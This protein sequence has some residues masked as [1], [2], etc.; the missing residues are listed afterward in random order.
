[1]LSVGQG[2]AH[3][4]VLAGRT[5]SVL[6]GPRGYDRARFDLG[7]SIAMCLV[8][9]GPLLV[10]GTPDEESYAQAVFS[11][12]MFWRYLFA[13]ADPNWIGDYGVGTLGPS[14]NWLILNFATAVSAW[15]GPQ[16]IYRAVWMTGAVGASF[17]CMR[18]LRDWDVG[19]FIRIAAG[20]TVLLS[21]PALAYSYVNDW[22]DTF[23]CWTASFVV[24]WA[25]LRLSRARIRSEIVQS[26]L[27]AG[28][29]AGF[30]AATS[31]PS[32]MFAPAYVLVIVAAVLIAHHP[33]LILFY[34][35][36]A[37][38]A[39][40]IASPLLLVVAR[41]I[42]EPF[43]A[44]EHRE[45]SNV[46]LSYVAYLGLRP[47][48]NAV[49]GE[50]VARLWDPYR[51]IFFGGVFFSGAVIFSCVTL[52]R[53]QHAGSGDPRIGAN[54]ALAIGFIAAVT[55][56]FAPHSFGLNLINGMWL[57]RD[58]ATLLGIPLAAIALSRVR[59][60]AVRNGLL[61]LHVLQ[62]GVV[63]I[64]PLSGPM[65]PKVLTNF[66][67]DRDGSFAT[68]LRDAD[69]PPH[70][71]ISL[72]GDLARESRRDMGGSG[73]SSSSD[74][75]RLGYAVVND[76]TWRGFVVPN[77]AATGPSKMIQG[78]TWSETALNS[79]TVRDF[80]GVRYVVGFSDEAQNRFDTT[81]LTPKV[82]ASLT[83]Q[84]RMATVFE[85]PTAWPRATVLSQEIFADYARLGPEVRCGL[86]CDPIDWNAYKIANPLSIELRD[87]SMLIHL[88]GTQPAGSILVI[89]QAFHAE[90]RV[91][92]D[93]RQVEPDRFLGAFGYV[94]L[95]GNERQILVQFGSPTKNA[96]TLVSVMTFVGGVVGLAVLGRRSRRRARGDGDRL[97]VT[98]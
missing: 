76:V 15:L 68:M 42:V 45:V 21:S 30:M 43:G 41:L 94:P 54:R 46:P 47:F 26:T 3:G 77:L 32:A 87:D 6:N 31:P 36:A 7:M 57:F 39:A 96:L 67:F 65:N 14:G 29:A 11:T 12:E 82:S 53:R 48:S 93:G 27:T 64:A 81:G 25:I 55:L 85:N 52:F 40:V 16:A 74:L 71:R 10:Y 92:V 63:S 24:L 35:V 80:L 97:N 70:A 4:T 18:I 50:H 38:I 13:G 86:A 98:L 61:G 89:T 8:V 66:R 91:V 69:I 78:L 34:A 88:D 33:R 60:G 49:F 20:F 90:W 84:G 2:P 23:S 79:S 72:A 37:A 28:L 17:F 44:W 56:V 83:G 5:N 75:V 1:M 22:P 59:V 19:G 62:I 51:A 95:A 58:P 73:V 9:F